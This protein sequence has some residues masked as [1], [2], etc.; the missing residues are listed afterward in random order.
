MTKQQIVKLR[1]TLSDEQ[2]EQS[3]VQLPSQDQRIKDLEPVKHV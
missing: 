1:E 2:S 3:V